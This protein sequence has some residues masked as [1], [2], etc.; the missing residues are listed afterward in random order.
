M[1]YADDEQEAGDG[2]DRP[3]DCDHADAEADVIEGTLTCRCGHRRSLADA[4]LRRE[5][6]QADAMEAQRLEAEAAT[7]RVASVAL[8]H[9]ATGLL[10]S[11]PAPARHHDVIGAMRRAGAPV[12]T[13]SACDQGF[14]DQGA[15][16][17]TREE[18]W[19]RAASNGQVR[20]T[21]ATPGTLYSEDVW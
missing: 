14:L 12:G 18:A 3:Y 17:L 10:L 6:E 8:R 5:M 21:P 15:S 1:A 9:P 16:Y 2:R 20:G 19:E 7:R 13:V 11:L 4:Q